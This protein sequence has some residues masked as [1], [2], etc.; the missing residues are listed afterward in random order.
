M[1]TPEI[2][3]MALILFTFFSFSSGLAWAST[4]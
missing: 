4:R 2:A 3:Y 1:S